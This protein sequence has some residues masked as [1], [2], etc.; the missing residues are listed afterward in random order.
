MQALVERASCTS[1]EMSL[2][3]GREIW[4]SKHAQDFSSVKEVRDCS[5]KILAIAVEL[6]QQGLLK[7]C[8]VRLYLRIVCASV[9]LLK[10]LSLGSPEADAAA[11]IETLE[12]A[13]EALDTNR[14]DDIHLSSR[15]S[16]LIGRHVQRFRAKFLVQKTDSRVLSRSRTQQHSPTREQTLGD[17]LHSINFALQPRDAFGPDPPDSLGQGF[18]DP[19]EIADNDNAELWWTQPFDPQI[20]PFGRDYMEPGVGLAA[21]SLDFLWNV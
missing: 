15:Y 9:F 13:I 1:D 8:P 18:A 21:D 7:H 17:D 16:I 3:P 11:S 10:A 4:R 20:A 12:Q 6:R 5:C 2:W 14:A 19:F